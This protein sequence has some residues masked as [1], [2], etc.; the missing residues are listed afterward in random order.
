M[1][2][3]VTTGIHAK[4]WY[5]AKTKLALATD[6]SQA[7]TLLDELESISKAEIQNAQDT[8]PLVEFDSRLG[9]EAAMEY[10]AHRENLE[11]KI[12][13]M[14]NIVDSQLKNERKSFLL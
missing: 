1:A 3:T 14:Q 12:A 13:Y 9:W 6:A 2:N 10:I 7:I 5:L 4:Q 11:W 8:I